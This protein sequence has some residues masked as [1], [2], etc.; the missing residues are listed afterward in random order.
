MFQGWIDEPVIAHDE[1]PVDARADNRIGGDAI[2]RVRGN[3]RTCRCFDEHGP[4]SPFGSRITRENVVRNAGQGAG[5]NDNRGSGIVVNVGGNERA[6]F[7]ADILDAGVACTRNFN[8]ADHDIGIAN[9]D[10]GAEWGGSVSLDAK[11]GEMRSGV[12]STNRLRFSEV[13]GV[14]AP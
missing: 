2:E 6:A 13:S 7:A 12:M 14:P 10:T 9:D 4:G 5:T 1:C 3:R 11:A 8:V